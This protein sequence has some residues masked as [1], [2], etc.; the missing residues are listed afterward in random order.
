[1]TASAFNRLKP[2][3]QQSWL[4]AYYYT[5]LAVSSPGVVETIAS[6]YWAYSGRDGQVSWSEWFEW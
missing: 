3:Y 4:P 2:V 5:E 6:T 1:L